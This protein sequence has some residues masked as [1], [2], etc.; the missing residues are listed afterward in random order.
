MPTYSHRPLARGLV[1]AAGCATEAGLRIGTPAAVNLGPLRWDDMD[2][3]WLSMTIRDK[4]GGERTIPLM[5]YVAHLLA[6][7]PRTS[8]FSQAPPPQM[9]SFQ[10]QCRDISGY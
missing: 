1:C 3:Q 5:P 10:S 4:V 7:L 6:A 8:G 9:D 2:F